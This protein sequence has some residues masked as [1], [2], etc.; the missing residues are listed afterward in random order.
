MS[1]ESTPP[2]LGL[3]AHDPAWDRHLRTQ[4]ATLRDRAP[5]TELADL[6]DDVLRGKRT[7][8][9]V[10]RTRA[11]NDAVRPAVDQMATAW[12]SLSEEEREE[13]A[14]QAADRIPQSEG[15]RRV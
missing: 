15:Q 13:L 6:L 8:R 11:F 9:D 12:A 2:L 4:I 5:G 10:A 7:L 1:D 3:T 14:R